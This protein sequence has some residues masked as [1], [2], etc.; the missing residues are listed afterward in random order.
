MP[1][2]VQKKILVITRSLPLLCLALC[3]AACQNTPPSQVRYFE[4]QISESGFLPRATPEAAGINTAAL[5][6][7]VSEAQSSHSHALI[8]IK[9]GRVVVE[10]YFGH[11]TGQ[12][13]R[14]NS[15][16]KSVVSLA[17]GMLI[18]DGKI[19][20][21][22]TPVSRW[23]PEWAKDKRAKI[24]LWNIMTHTSGL[25]HEPSAEK[26]YK[27]QNVVQYAAGLKTT[28]EP[29]RSFSYSNEALAL[30]PGIVKSASGIS[31][32]AYLKE[33]LFV[34]MGIMSVDWDRDP[35][36]N[37][38]PYGGLWLMPRDLARIGQL[39]VDSGRWNGKQLVPASWTRAATTP[40][41]SDLSYYGLLWWLYPAPA[42]QDSDG[43][44]PESGTSAFHTGG[45]G[46]D[47][48]LGQYLVVYPQWNLVA[49]RMH[50]VEAGNNEA[51]NR[52]Y[53]FQSF[54]KLTLAL[55]QKPAD[56]QSGKYNV[57]V[58]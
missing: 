33:R 5:A 55:V 53:G 20:G 15:V 17:I 36:G 52:K 51:E 57:E 37:V 39:M 47:G 46:A 21:L 14:T 10:R 41:R 54:Q 26:L 58:H 3:F 43:I 12:P 1:Y 28:D 19:P 32:E 9:D 4:P 22:N 45:F 7:L 49:V 2:F 42:V 8:V 50:G 34:P 40:A 24:T 16:T 29:G 35:A 27:Q 25:Y 23:Y 6:S 30:I 56:Q 31:L 48:W 11:Y 38:M 13:L 44:K 18:N